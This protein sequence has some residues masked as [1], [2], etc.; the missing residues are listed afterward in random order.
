VTF[1]HVLA[2]AGA[3]V[4]LAA[5]R[6]E[7]LEE[8]AA[9]I[10]G[11]GGKVLVQTCDVSN[12]A[13]VAAMVDAAWKRFGR[14]DILVNNAGVAAEA[15]VFP[16]RTPDELWLTT[17]GVNLNGLFWCCRE[18]AQR[19]LADGK[20]GSIINVSSVMGL[21][22]AQH[23]AA[24]YQAS[25]GAVVNLTRNLGV[26]WANRGV[27]VNCLAPGWFPSEMTNDWFAVPE[28]NAR[29]EGSAP[30]GRI[31]DPDELAGALLFL[32]SDASS[33]VTGQTI[34]VD[35]GLS[36][37]GGLAPPYS[38]ELYAAQAAVV[39]EFGTPIQPPA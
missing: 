20:G 2:E 30:M 8:V 15:G 28:F 22:G 4:V 9:H 38:D 37:A 35:G 10:R 17:I 3:N 19:Q 39:G 26:S 1:A 33:F 32:A 21:S 5:R 18:V 11:C 13:E 24:A 29:F 27:R 34:V 31:G 14:V 23:M 7:K 36:A 12:S 6:T 25:K 16:E